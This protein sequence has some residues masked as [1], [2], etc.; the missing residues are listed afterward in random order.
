MAMFR[1]F[2]FLF[3]AMSG[4]LAPAHAGKASQEG[5]YQLRIYQVP[6]ENEDVFHERFRDHALRIMKTYDFNI[7]AMWESDFEG[8]TEFVYLLHWPDEATKEEK[9]AAFLADQ[10]WIAIKKQTG[11][12][13]GSFVNAIEDRTLDLTDYSPG[14]VSAE[15]K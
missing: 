2:T 9:W 11:A 4:V 6:G 10:E 13:H 3:L 1:K 5:V 8:R 15:K 7:L 14:L 12:A